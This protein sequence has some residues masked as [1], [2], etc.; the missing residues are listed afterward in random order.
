MPDSEGRCLN[1]ACAETACLGN[2]LQPVGGTLSLVM[3]HHKNE[4][5]W[6]RGPIEVKLPEQLHDMLMCLEED[7]FADL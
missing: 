3:P 2:I 7:E 4:S 6:G 5:N 1:G